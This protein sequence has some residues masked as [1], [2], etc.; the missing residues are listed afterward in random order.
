MTEI[1]YFDKDDEM[2]DG[3]GWNIVGEVDDAVACRFPTLALA[4]RWCLAMGL[5]FRVEGQ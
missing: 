1:I 3:N 5:E 4:K 2:M